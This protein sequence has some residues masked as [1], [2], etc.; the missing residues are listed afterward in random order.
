[1][2][3]PGASSPE[4]RARMQAVKM[5]DTGPELR[6]RHLIHAVGLR[7]LV[8]HPL[9]LKG[10][11]RRSD[12]TFRSERVVVFVDGSYWHGCPNHWRPPKSNT[13]W[14]KAKIARNRARDAE[15]NELMEAEGWLVVRVWE[16]EDLETGYWRVLSAL[17]SRGSER[18]SRLVSER[19]GTASS[20]RERCTAPS[21]CTDGSTPRRSLTRS[22]PTGSATS[23]SS[24]SSAKDR[25][26]T[27]SAGTRCA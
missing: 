2:T 13:E 15:T 27:T 3:A 26:R 19:K 14:W 25:S 24:A 12:L 16:C 1:M 23:S 4:V 18:A 17:A 7:Y 21:S 9:P 6:L 20:G 8:D 11:R 22:T 10:L 5:T